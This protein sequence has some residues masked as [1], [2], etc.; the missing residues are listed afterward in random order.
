M[1]LA[2][3]FRNRIVGVLLVLSLFLILLPAMMSDSKSKKYDENLISINED[4]AL[5]DAN[6]NLLA[7]NNDYAA[8]LSDNGS[9]TLNKN[10]VNT[11]IGN[12]GLPTVNNSNENNDIEELLANNANNVVKTQNQNN[13]VETL[14]A[15]NKVNTAPKKDV[16]VLVA[17]NSKKENAPKKE[18]LENKVNNSTN[19]IEMSKSGSFT[20]QVGVF[21]DVNNANKLKNKLTN[22]G[23]YSYTQKVEVNGKSLTR[24]YAIKS[25]DK[26]K[27][28]ALLPKIKS[29]T[30]QDGKVVSAQ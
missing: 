25:N 13:K 22:A 5:T 1:A 24:V 3:K 4:G 12:D 19:A 9:D 20:I 21:S 6:G 11:Q 14:V 16:E 15:D 17:N 10:D 18:V 8:L 30:G 28:S 26:A 29:I 7:K 27:L 2:N 23:I